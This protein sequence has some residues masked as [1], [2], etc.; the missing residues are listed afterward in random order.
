MF[1]AMYYIY[2]GQST[3]GHEDI[4][5]ILDWIFVVPILNIGSQYFQYLEKE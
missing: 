3:M 1:P 4:G 5:D 2:V